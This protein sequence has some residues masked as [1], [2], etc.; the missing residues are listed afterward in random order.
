MTPMTL[1][2]RYNSKGFS[3][4]ELLLALGIFA[5]VM[6]GV[7]A[8]LQTYTERELARA[9][10]RYMMAVLGA[11]K[12]MLQDPINF[13]ALYEATAATGG[14]YQLIADEAAAASDN[15]LKDFVVTSVAT[16]PVT[17]QA[18]R[19]LNSRFTQNSPIRAQVRILL[20]I[21]DTPPPNETD[22]RAME[23]FVVTRAPRPDSIVQK[24]ANEGGYNGGYIRTYAN[25]AAALMDNSFNGWRMQMDANSRLTATNWYTG[26]LQNTLNSNTD[27]SYLVYYDYVNLQ[28]IA[29]DYLYRVEDPSVSKELNT[30]YGPMNLGGNDIIGADD[31]YIGNGAIT[32]TFANADP[33]DICNGGVLCVDGIGIVKGSASAGG[34][35]TV[36]GSALVADSGNFNAMRIQNGLTS[37]ADRQ[38]YGAQ[39]LFVVDGDEDGG[40]GGTTDTVTVGGVAT[41]EDGM[42]VNQGNLGNITA[43]DMAIP[44]NGILQAQRITNARKISAT[45]INANSLTTIGQL[46][47][48]IVTGG[49]VDVTGR[50]GVID[51]SA[52]NN[53]QLGTAATPQN[54]TVPRLRVNKL[55]VNNFGACGDCPQ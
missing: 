6:M 26:D 29:S 43:T 50:A 24:A 18:S 34:N 20:R 37:D 27:G 15:I 21:S 38:A 54:L 3:L 13:N 39:G 19:L 16:G 48:G 14:G 12:A 17:I 32:N 30:M 40:G 9:T 23:I 55:L 52:M 7:L 22:V 51:I 42:T 28:D 33:N 5:S 53:M 25:K 49:N 31:V 2:T 45:A 47:S 46:K 36:S 41:F 4:M 10:N 35:M 11:T 44:E 8:L 1:R